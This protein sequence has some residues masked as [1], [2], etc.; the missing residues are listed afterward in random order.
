MSKCI[1]L[2]KK[3]LFS[4]K[5]NIN[6]IY[7]FLLPFSTFLHSTAIPWDQCFCYKLDL[8]WCMFRSI[9]PY[10]KVQLQPANIMQYLNMVQSITVIPLTNK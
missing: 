10:Q 2:Q 8:V 7:N 5:Y 9:L 4:Y 3:C 6:F 1:V